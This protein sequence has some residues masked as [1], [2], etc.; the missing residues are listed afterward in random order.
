MANK[1]VGH[2]SSVTLLKIA[3]N[4]LWRLHFLGDTLHVTPTDTFC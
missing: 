2:V 4:S 1:E 3:C